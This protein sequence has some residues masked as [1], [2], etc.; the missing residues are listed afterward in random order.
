MA[1][2]I[3]SWF[4]VYGLDGSQGGAVSGWPFLQGPNLIIHDIE[5]STGYHKWKSTSKI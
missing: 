1:S 5:F 3:V 4:G 2:A